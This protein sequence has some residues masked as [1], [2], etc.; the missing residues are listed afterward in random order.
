MSLFSA[1]LFDCDGVLVDSEPITNA[2]LRQ[3]LQELGWDISAEESIRRFVGRSFIDEWKVIYDH[4]GVRIDQDWI[5]AFRARRDAA[6][7]ERLTAVPGAVDAVREIAGRLPVACVSG[8]DRGKIEMQLAMVG[9]TDVFAGRVFSGMEMER[10]K[11]APD[12]YL[13][14][15]ASLGIDPTMAAVVEDSASGIRAGLSA[16]ATVFGF[17]SDGPTYLAPEALLGLGVSATFGS[18]AELPGLVASGA[19]QERRAS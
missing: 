15:A 18:M 16:G 6:L 2:V 19:R 17:A 12:V 9:L 11:P 4:T 8:A 13:A 14:A 10:S 1:V 7:R 3:M 5:L